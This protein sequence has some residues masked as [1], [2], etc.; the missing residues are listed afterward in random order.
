VLW[1]YVDN[2]IA[3]EN[4]TKQF[5]AHGISVDRLVFLR[6]LP[7]DEYLSRYFLADLFLDTFPYNAGTTA[8]D[9]LWMGLPILTLAGQS[10]VSRMAIS[11]L[12]N[13]GSDL[14]SRSLATFSIRQ[15]ESQAV[16]IALNSEK[17]M[18][19]KTELSLRRT[20]APLFDTRAF[21]GHLEVAFKLAWSRYGAGLPTEH[22]TV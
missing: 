11:L 22:L 16:E 9:A 21:A 5:I 20:A 4:L 6:R 17:L 2:S 7:R 3:E 10:F 12:K 15:Y 14:L 19:I 13:L 18:E 8:S 1:L